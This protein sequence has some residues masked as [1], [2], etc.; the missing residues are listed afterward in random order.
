MFVSCRPPCKRSFK[1]FRTRAEAIAWIARVQ[2]KIVD[3]H[4]AHGRTIVNYFLRLA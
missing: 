3:I 1:A 2:Y 4:D